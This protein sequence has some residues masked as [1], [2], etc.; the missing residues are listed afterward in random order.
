MENVRAVTAALV[1]VGAC[2]VA[3]YVGVVEWFVGGIV[4]VVDGIKA[5][6]TNGEAIAWG[7]A[8]VFILAEA[9]AFAIVM[10]GWGLAA[11]I[12]PRWRR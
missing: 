8:K 6:P 7:L 12:W 11:L 2:M 10:A 5:D 4:Q 3:A 1:F 9:A